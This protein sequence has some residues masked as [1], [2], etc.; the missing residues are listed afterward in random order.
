MFLTCVLVNLR[1]EEPTVGEIS[2]DVVE[3]DTEIELALD[4]VEED[5]AIDDNDSDFD[6]DNEM[7]VDD[8]YLS[9]VSSRFQF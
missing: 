6:E 3:A 8:L 2:N 9:N 1:P 4:K 5:M 7:D